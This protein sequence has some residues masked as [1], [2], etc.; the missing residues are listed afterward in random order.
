MFSRKRKRAVCRV[1]ARDAAGAVL[2][3]APAGEFPLPEAAT[4]ALSVEF[5]NDPEPCE[6]HRA[7]VRSRALRELEERCPKGETVPVEA[8][9]ERLSRLFPEGTRSVAITEDAP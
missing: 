2:L 4:V 5:F 8:L 6:I 3:S 9:G 1:T 7:A